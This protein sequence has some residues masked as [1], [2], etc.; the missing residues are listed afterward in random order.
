MRLHANR[1]PKC[2]DGN[3]RLVSARSRTITYCTLMH[4]AHKMASWNHLF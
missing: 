4:T 3:E 2:H 1:C